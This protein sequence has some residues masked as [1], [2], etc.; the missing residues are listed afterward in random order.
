MKKKI[1]SLVLLALVLYTLPV[2]ATA[3]DVSTAQTT[4]SGIFFMS[5]NDQTGESVSYEINI[6]GYYDTASKDYMEITAQNVS[7]GSTKK[8]AV[9]LDG[10]R[11]FGDT[12]ILMLSHE[13]DPHYRA[14]CELY[15]TCDYYEGPLERIE[16]PEDILVATFYDGDENSSSYGKIVA[17]ITAFDDTISGTYTG[18]IYFKIA[19]ENL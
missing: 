10:E 11:T 3:I 15:R 14:K 19:V 13:N 18:T 16:T 1:I 2:V 6:P 12:G 5:Q 4:V 9:Y 7:I 8:V 17:N